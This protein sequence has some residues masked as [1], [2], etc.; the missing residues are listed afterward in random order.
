MALD[1]LNRSGPRLAA[2]ESDW[3]PQRAAAEARARR[4]RSTTVEAWTWSTE[5][6][7]PSHPAFR[8]RP[9][10]CMQLTSLGRAG[11]GRRQHARSLHGR[12]AC[13][14]ARRHT[15]PR[16][17]SI[18]DPLTLLRKFT[19]GKEPVTLEG[20]H[21]VLG[22]T[23]FEASAKTAYKMGGKGEYYSLHSLWFLL[24]N[25]AKP[26][27]EYVRDCGQAGI[28]PVSVIDRR[29][30][31][32]YLRGEESTSRNID[33]TGYEQPQ[34]VRADASAAAPEDAAAMEVDAEIDPSKAREAAELESKNLEVSKAAFLAL[35]EQPISV[36]VESCDRL[37][38]PSDT[39]RTD[40]E[41]LK[42]VAQLAKPWIKANQ[43]RRSAITKRER[44]NINRNTMLL[45]PNT[46]RLTGVFNIL[47]NF[48]KMNQLAL[49]KNRG[50][51]PEPP[52]GASAKA[53]SS[54]KAAAAAPSSQAPSAAPSGAGPSSAPPAKRPREAAPPVGV[55]VVPAAITSIVNMWNAAELLQSSAFTPAAEKKA[56]GA[57]KSA[58]FKVCSRARAARSGMGKTPP[59]HPD[60][61]PD[62]TLSL[63][64]LSLSAGARVRGR[65]HR[66]VPRHGQ[67]VE[68][69]QHGL[70]LPGVRR[71]AGLGVAVQGVAV[72]GRR[73][74]DLLEGVRL[75][76]PL[77]ARE[78]Q[79]DGQG[80]AP[81]Q[82]RLLRRED[83]QARGRRADGQL[84][85][86]APQVHRLEEAL[87]ARQ[88]QEGRHRPYRAL[89]RVNISNDGS[90]GA[91]RPR[92]LSYGPYR[93]LG[94]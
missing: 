6:R 58:S 89:R 84:L 42:L 62:P 1:T 59:P 78:A 40:T 18:S 90:G 12:R 93:W 52:K 87:P 30:L 88:A 24:Q 26:V 17:M 70:E 67:P 37:C 14:A 33:Y 22:D 9:G 11:P 61:R 2:V 32:R 46:E 35:L 92:A 27:A 13:R 7:K 4:A 21:I 85:G 23:R 77:H 48:K 72:Q 20:E 31:L 49:K 41:R 75:L 50:R 81:Q 55:I 36:S 54:S 8:E 25:E 94:L 64:P 76:L 82:P 43:E 38:G 80:V 15:P 79:P 65:H 44:Q 53:S 28:I 66:H 56:Q 51:I 69:A 91:P 16:A 86:L 73:G 10:Q 63:A 57:T 47:D 45:A 34:P 68:A 60:P 19:M 3:L 83:A 29:A 71:R 5:Q 74:R 39:P